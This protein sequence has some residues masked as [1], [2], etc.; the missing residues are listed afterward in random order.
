MAEFARLRA[1]VE[2]TGMA[3][4]AA[5]QRHV[6]H[7]EIC[8]YVTA[9]A[10]AETRWLTF[11]EANVPRC[12]IPAQIASQLKQMHANTEQTTENICAARAGPAVRTPA[13]D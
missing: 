1:D 10:E 7:D 6:S 11:T 3:A 5:S 13:F 9:Y 12:G 8:R 4:R 2:K